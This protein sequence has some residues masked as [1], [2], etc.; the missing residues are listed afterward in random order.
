MEKEY[1]EWEQKLPSYLKAKTVAW[2]DNTGGDITKAEVCPGKV[3]VYY[4][5]RVATLWNNA[6]ILRLYVSGVIV[7]CAAWICSP[8]DYRTTPEYSSASRLCLDLVTDIIAS[9]PFLLGWRHGTQDGGMRTED[10][11][12]FTASL[13]NFGSRSGVGGFFAM[14]PLFSVSNTDFITDS[15]R[16]WVKGR[17]IFISEIMGLNHAKVLST[18]RLPPLPSLQL[19]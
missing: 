19:Y 17:L 3:D 11:P 14:W 6:R 16:A 18:V 1:Q 5:I 2:V 4:D 9:T 7:R 13:G 12:H 15:Q 8:V 10:L